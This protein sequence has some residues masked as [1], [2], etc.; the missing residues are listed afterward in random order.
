MEGDIMFTRLPL[1]GDLL[2]QKRKQISKL[3]SILKQLDANS[4]QSPQKLLAHYEKLVL[5]YK[6]YVESD[7]AQPPIK[8]WFNRYSL[9][10]VRLEINTLL[11]KHQLK[12]ELLACIKQL[13]VEDIY[14]HYDSKDS[15]LKIIEK[16]LLKMNPKHRVVSLGGGNNPVLHIILDNK[17]DF[18]IRLVR[19]NS[20]EDASG[21]SPRAARESLA[22]A[23][24]I[25]QP[26]FMQRLEDD[27]QEVTYIECNEYYKFGNLADLFQKLHQKT[28][29]NYT[30]IN[31]KVIY[32]F[33]KC[34]ELYGQL[35][36]R[37][38]WYT[39]LKPSNLL[40]NDQGQL[41]V[42]DIKGLVVSDQNL[43]KS[44][45]TNTTATYFQSSAY[46]GNLVNLERL[47]RQTLANSIYQM[48]TNKMPEF[49][50]K[51]LYIREC[52]Y[53][54]DQ[55]CF[56]NAEGEFLKMMIIQL[57]KPKQ[58]DLNLFLDM[59]KDFTF[60]EGQKITPMS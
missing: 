22:G 50:K 21:R 59:I 33:Q 38:I 53:D 31:L 15:F 20:L 44:S 10:A 57:N 23:S 13:Q 37:Q 17:Y 42:S 32:Y 34:L 29:K 18:I 28:D 49:V 1:E 54:F 46:E 40:L 6:K 8:Q 16:R 55:P 3:N 35:N 45:K 26:Y 11:L 24:Q 7:L 36:K 43:I 52:K 2:S 30:E 39:D 27:Q 9:D 4:S 56:Q 14:K 51:D 60:N 12:V 58:A 25:P 48:M 41:V 5:F 47:Q 19:M